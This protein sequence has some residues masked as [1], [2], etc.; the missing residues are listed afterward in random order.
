MLSSPSYL[1][2]FRGFEWANLN[3]IKLLLLRWE[4]LGESDE[5]DGRNLIVQCDSTFMQIRLRIRIHGLSL[6]INQKIQIDQ[7]KS[8]SIQI[9]QN[10]LSSVTQL[11]VFPQL[12]MPAWQHRC[13]NVMQI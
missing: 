1:F 7:S 8:K 13:V 10:E 5:T 11:Y 4:C 2:H 12:Q 9:D 6:K 3:F